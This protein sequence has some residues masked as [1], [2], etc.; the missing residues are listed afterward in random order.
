VPPG[1]PRR[2]TGGWRGTRR[3]GGRRGGARGPCRGRGWSGGG[4]RAHRFCAGPPSGSLSSLT[5]RARSHDSHAL[6]A[7]QTLP[8]RSEPLRR[9]VQPRFVTSSS[10]RQSGRSHRARGKVWAQGDA[11]EKRGGRR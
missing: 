9:T 7:A 11:G 8:R 3:R 10:N 4:A 2:G 1:R 5:P 6:R